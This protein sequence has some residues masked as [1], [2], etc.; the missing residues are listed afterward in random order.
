MALR[1]P[2]MILINGNPVPYDSEQYRAIVRVRYRRWLYRRGVPRAI[3]AG[4]K[5]VAALRA[6]AIIV[7]GERRP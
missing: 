2:R 5:T 4:L 3:T 7:A 6:L 1:P